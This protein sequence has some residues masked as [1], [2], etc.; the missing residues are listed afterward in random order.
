MSYLLLNRCSAALEHVFKQNLVRSIAAKIN[1]LG[2]LYLLGLVLGAKLFLPGP[3]FRYQEP[4][5][6]SIQVS[7]LHSQ[8]KLQRSRNRLTKTRGKLKFLRTKI[9]KLNP[10]VDSHKIANIIFQVSSEY[11]YDPL[12]VASIIK[13]ESYFNRKAQS[14]KGARGLMQLMPATAKYIAGKAGIKWLGLSKLNDPEYNIKLGITYFSYLKRKYRGNIHHA[15][16]AYN[17]GP[18]HLNSALR[19]RKAIYKPVLKYAHKVEANHLTWKREH[20]GEVRSRV[21]KT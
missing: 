3:Q 6:E 20:Q 14:N 7:F 13:V 10:K 4:R 5:E 21:K 11:D 8:F 2:L 18:G 9:A 16:M 12:A 17:W 19:K 15:L 1:V